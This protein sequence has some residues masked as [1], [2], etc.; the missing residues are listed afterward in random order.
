MHLL[1]GLTVVFLA[2]YLLPAG[3]HDLG[4]VPPSTG[5]PASNAAVLDYAAR[6]EWKVDI[7]LQQSPG[8]QQPQALRVRVRSLLWGG[9]ALANSLLPTE[10]QSSIYR[11]KYLDVPQVLP[12]LPFQLIEVDWNT[13]G[14][15]RGPNNSFITP[16]YDFHFYTKS[17]AFVDS[18][19]NCVTSGKTCD[20]QK[21]DYAQMRRF[22]ELPATEFMPASAFPDTG[23]SIAA[24]GLHSLDGTFDFTVESVNHNPV[25]IYGSFAGE[26]AFLEAS[27][28]LYA[29]SDAMEAA[30]SDK[31][32]NWPIAQPAEYAYPWWPT[33]LSLEYVQK[34]Q[35]FYVELGGF[36]YHEYEPVPQVVQ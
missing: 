25:I 10:P 15:P 8:M 31:K 13:E 18:R 33:T 7:S 5:Y 24:M 17:S 3:A 32:S 28:T 29:F 22:L 6:P 30:A 21:T 4:L 14:L 2:L 35:V 19:M 26:I 16:H 34:E 1:S 27:M 12:A 23:S 36:V 20:A 9:A 11:F